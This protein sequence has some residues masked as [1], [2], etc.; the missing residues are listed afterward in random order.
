MDETD[1]VCDVEPDLVG[2]FERL[3]PALGVPVPVRV[4][5]GVL[6]VDVVIVAVFDVDV[7]TVA[8]FDGVTDGV[9][10]NDGVLETLLVADLVPVGERLGDTVFVLVGLEPPLGVLVCDGVNE[11]VFVTDTV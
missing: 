5:D 11:G 2:V 10:D 4:T 1:G 6:D 9:L 8:V 7:V 3:E